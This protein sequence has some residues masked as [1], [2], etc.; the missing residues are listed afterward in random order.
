MMLAVVRPGSFIVTWHIPQSIVKEDIPNR[1]MKKYSVINLEI[2]G[3]NISPK[4]PVSI[5]TAVA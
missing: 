1:I 5:V 4:Q 3:I 2:A